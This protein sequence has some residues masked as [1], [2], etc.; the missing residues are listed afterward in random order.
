M[1]KKHLSLEKSRALL[2]KLERE[3][4]KLGKRMNAVRLQIRLLLARKTTKQTCRV[5]KNGE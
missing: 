3:M 5:S 2:A 1:V 4:F